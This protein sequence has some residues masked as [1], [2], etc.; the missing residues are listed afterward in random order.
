MVNNFKG[1]FTNAAGKT[2]VKTVSS[3]SKSS[4]QLARETKEAMK[5]KGYKYSSGSL[6]SGP[7]AW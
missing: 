1:K 6:G 2:V 3:S 4:T 5:N 7:K